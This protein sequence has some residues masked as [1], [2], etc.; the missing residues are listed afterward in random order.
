MLYSKSVVSFV[1]NVHI[2]FQSGHDMADSQHLCMKDPVFLHSCQQLV[3]FLLLK[4]QKLPAVFPVFYPL[5]KSS[6]TYSFVY[7]CIGVCV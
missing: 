5:K 4:S 6:I 3:L 7:V 2:I 1:R